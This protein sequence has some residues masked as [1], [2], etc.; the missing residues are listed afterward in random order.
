MPSALADGIATVYTFNI[1]SISL[2]K[3]DILWEEK[4]YARAA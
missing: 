1:E 2:N 3:E 4:V